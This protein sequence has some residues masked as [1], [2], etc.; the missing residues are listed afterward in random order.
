MKRGSS[1]V[2][3]KCHVLKD[4]SEYHPSLKGSICKECY[5]KQQREQQREKRLSKRLSSASEAGSSASS[6]DHS[7][8]GESLYI[9]TNPRIPGELKIGRA[10]CPVGRAQQLS[11]GQNYTLEVNH[12]YPQ[13]GFLESTVHRRLAPWQVT[14][15]HSREWFKLLPEQADVLIR[16]A[17]L[18]YDLS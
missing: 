5:N 2:C 12:A 6:S 3:S 10:A 16:A 4:M 8:W 15:G 17:I 11:Q 14:T 13:K 7:T 18:E 9:L 1:K